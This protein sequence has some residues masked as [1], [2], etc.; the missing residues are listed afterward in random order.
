MY[1]GISDTAVEHGRT[2]SPRSTSNSTTSS[3]YASTSSMMS[4]TMSPSMAQTGASKA[5]Y[6]EPPVYPVTAPSLTYAYSV[7]TTHGQYVSQDSLY[8][9]AGQIPSAGLGGRG[10]LDWASYIDTS[11]P[12]PNNGLEHATDAH[13]KMMSPRTTQASRARDLR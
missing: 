12:M 13:R 10:S 5:A 9:S 8:P 11:P 7:P 6:S 1:P 3:A 4:T 2:A